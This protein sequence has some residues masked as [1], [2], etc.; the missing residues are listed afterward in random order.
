MP[1]E[2]EALDTVLY[3]LPDWIAEVVEC[4]PLVE[5]AENLARCGFAPRL[6]F[7]A[8]LNE[9]LEDRGVEFVKVLG[10]KR[11]WCGFAHAVAN[12]YRYTLTKKFVYLKVNSFAKTKYWVHRDTTTNWRGTLV[13]ETGRRAFGAPSTALRRTEACPSYDTGP[14]QRDPTTDAQSTTDVT[15]GDRQRVPVAGGTL[16]YETRGLGKE[17]VGFE[18]VTDWDDLAD[19]LE[20]LN[21]PAVDI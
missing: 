21:A 5:C 3:R 7:L 20:N 18:D 13:G 2:G 9:V 6:T 14:P 8:P 16:V 19:V 12:S 11:H 15:P 10:R 4:T 17:F 1:G